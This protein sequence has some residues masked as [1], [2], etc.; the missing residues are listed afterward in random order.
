MR[1]L[2]LSDTKDEEK[3]EETSHGPQMECSL[4]SY[5]DIMKT[6]KDTKAFVLI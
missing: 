2:L 1:R 6:L 3:E 4:K 5:Y